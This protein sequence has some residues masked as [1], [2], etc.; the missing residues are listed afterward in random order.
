MFL[1]YISVFHLILPKIKY[2]RNINDAMRF[3]NQKDKKYIIF[4]FVYELLRYILISNE[5]N[6]LFVLLADSEPLR[7]HSCDSFCNVVNDVKRVLT[8]QNTLDF[9]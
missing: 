4:S 5:I 3:K 7:K 1:L 8:L 9:Y 2:A 6:A